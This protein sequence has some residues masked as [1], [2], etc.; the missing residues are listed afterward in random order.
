M[1]RG[2]ARTKRP[3]ET[4]QGT[5]RFARPTHWTPAQASAVF[6]L[7]DELREWV[8]LSYGSQ[9]QQELRRDHVVT[10]SAGPLNLGDEDVPF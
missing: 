5:A 2:H 8:W 7:L 9:I 6:E 1:T 10:T 4:D 3:P